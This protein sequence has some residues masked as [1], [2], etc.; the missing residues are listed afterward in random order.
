MRGRLQQGRI[1]IRIPSASRT[2]MALTE[3]LWVIFVILNGNSIY[4]ANSIRNLYLV[5]IVLLLTFLLAAMNILFYR[6]WPTKKS[7]IGAVAI[8]CYCSVYFSVMQ[9]HM[10]AKTYMHLFM[11]GA[12]AAFVMFSESYRHGRLIRLLG[13]ITDV[14]CIL[15]LISLYFW[16]MGEVFKLI[17]PNGYVNIAWGGFDE[18]KGYYGIHFAFQLDTT[19]FPDAFLF[20]NS[21]IF[22]EAPMF[23]FWLDVAMAI[24]LFMKPRASVLRILILGITVFTTLS[25]TGILFMVICVILCFMLRIGRMNRIQRAVFF[26]VALVVIPLLIV[27]VFKSMALKVDTKSYEMRLSDYVGGVRMWMDYPLFGNGFGN[28]K[29]FQDY[30]AVSNGVVGFSNSITAVLGTGGIWMALLYYVPHICMMFPKLTG[31]KKIACFGVCLMFLFITTI[32]FARCIGML[33]VVLGYALM[34]GAKEP[35]RLPEWANPT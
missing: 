26:V 9:N 16:F 3:Y 25:V 18:V 33:L 7:V 34:V 23:N 14:M 22:S 5:E 28:L 10:A 15:A 2:I 6:S 30:V 21:S 31:G 32:T 29:G 13:R 1:L 8:L 12:P 35:D 11:L 4:H 27:V 24:E 20:R 17:K 19:F